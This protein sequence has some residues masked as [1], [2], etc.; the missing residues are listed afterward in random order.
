[1]TMIVRYEVTDLASK[2]PGSSSPVVT[3]RVFNA[4]LAL[5][6][7]EGKARP[8]L[9]DALPRLNSESW[10]VS[11]DGSME[12]TYKLR[13]GLTWHDGT[14][15]TA[16]DF[17][18]AM[19]VYG[20]SALGIFSPTPQ[21]RIEQ[22]LAP[23]AQTVR[24]VWKSL[25]ADAG[26]LVDEDLDP[27]PRHILG[28]AFEALEQ[29]SST[30]ESFVNL[31]FWSSEYVGAGPFRLEQWVPGSHFEARAFDGHALGRPRVDRLIIR[32][33]GDENTTMSMVLA[34]ETDFTANFTLRFANGIVLKREWEA[35]KRGTV[36]LKP[37]GPV[38]QMVQFRP[39]YLMHQGL[40]DVRVR[41]AL[42]HA[43]DREGLN[44]GLFEGQGFVSESLVPASVAYY[45]DVD[46]AM[47]KHPYD[48]SRAAQYMSDAGYRKG[49]DGMFVDASGAPFRTD[50]RVTEG[51]EFERGQAILVDAWKRAG[52]DVSGSV[53]ARAQ[54][55]DREAR[56]TFPGMASRGGGTQE[57]SFITSEVGSP[58]DRWTGANRGG[59]SNPQYDQLYETFL[60]SL[61]EGERTRQ[62][63]GMMKLISEQLPVY[64]MYHAIQVNTQSAALVGPT[65]ETTGF[66][67]STRGTL[68][69]WNIH[70]W[71]VR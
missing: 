7:G 64:A 56:Q 42:A 4:A 5:I 26:S 15:L 3:K 41:R 17:A 35:A 16:A 28:T 37:S 43:I 44:E 23:D 8:Y 9:A 29:D 55:R 6:D 66:G 21:D 32:V 38:T 25:Y 1:M 67:E 59:W 20:S 24:I 63:I 45:A 13:S 54:A 57:R 61:D 69:Y 30:A 50:L 12:T 58:D 71:E 39:E 49:S 33:V 52:F 2:I 27:L 11:P 51:P 36:I 40:L 62:V 22:V 48:T 34:G 60:T 18:F 14:P 53:L 31:P 46:R 68:L 47:A 70:E 65:A 19:R 10:R